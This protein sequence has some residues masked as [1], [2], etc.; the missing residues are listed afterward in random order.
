M[1]ATKDRDIKGRRLLRGESKRDGAVTFGETHDSPT[2][3]THAW[4][5][6]LGETIFDQARE[7]P[8]VDQ[9]RN[10]AEAILTGMSCGSQP[11]P[12]MIWIIRKGAHVGRADVQPMALVFGRVSEPAANL[13]AG[14]DQSEVNIFTT[15]LQQVRS[16]QRSARAPA[17][18]GDGASVRFHRAIRQNDSL[19]GIRLA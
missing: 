14:F 16:D 7:V 3:P 17:D 4:R 15:A 9:A 6:G 8:A 12:E 11:P 10:R 13:R 18:D 5:T 1:S 2:K 19:P